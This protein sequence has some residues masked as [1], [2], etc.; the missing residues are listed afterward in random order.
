[1]IT[2][3]FEGAPPHF[4][5]LWPRPALPRLASVFPARPVCRAAVLDVFVTFIDPDL[6]LVQLVSLGE[7]W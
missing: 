6:T 1:M 2:S 7:S 3:L 5:S 4:S